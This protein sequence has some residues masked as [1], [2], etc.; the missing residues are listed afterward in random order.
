MNTIE[1]IKKLLEHPQVASGIEARDLMRVIDTEGDLHHLLAPLLAGKRLEYLTGG[2][3][4]EDSESEFQFVS[5]QYRI[6]PETIKIGNVEINAPYREAP[7]VGT[8][9]FTPNA[10]HFDLVSRLKWDG[11]S[12][13]LRALDAGLVLK[14][15]EDALAAHEAISKLMRGAE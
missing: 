13:D 14:T 7:P 12:D 8:I 11:N 1:T 2:R 10:F 6:K 9:Y 3:W 5:D 4:I 15:A